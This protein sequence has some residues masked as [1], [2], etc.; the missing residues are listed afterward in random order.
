MKLKPPTGLGNLPIIRSAGNVY[1]R[2]TKRGMYL[3]KWPRPWKLNTAGQQFN[4][5]QMAVSAY[6]IKLATP[7]SIDAAMHWEKNSNDTWKDA[8]T[9]AQFGTLFQVELSDGTICGIADHG[10]I[11]PV[12]PEESEVPWTLIKEW[13]FS[14]DG[15]T[16]A[17]NITDLA[18]YHEVAIAMNAVGCSS[19]A[20][21]Q[22]LASTDNG[23]TYASAAGN[24]ESIQNNSVPATQNAFYLSITQS[25]AVLSSLTIISFLNVGLK[26][27]V[28]QTNPGG[29][30]GYR[31]IKDDLPINA[32]RLRPSAGNFNSGRFGIFAR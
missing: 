28:S 24:Y 8:M 15:A 30:F 22:A 18:A 17:I 23:L 26:Y 32:I 2:I 1:T 5:D 13:T 4:R 6:M 19:S 10:Y 14:I 20:F 31:Y 21:R 25:T 9:R 7:E 16:N 27:P 29:T 3:S 12:E 11:A